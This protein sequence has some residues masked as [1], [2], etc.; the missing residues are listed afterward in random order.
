MDN[1]IYMTKKSRFPVF[2]AIALVSIL[3]LSFAVT[4]CRAKL[5]GAE[6]YY[7]S[8][9]DS[10][11]NL[12][13]GPGARYPV[14]WILTRETMPVKIIREFDVWRQIELFD[15][16]TGWVHMN[17]LSGRKTAIV[18][19]ETREMRVKPAEDARIILR[20]E[21]GVIVKLDQCVKAWCSIGVSG[22]EGWIPAA[23]LWGDT[24]AEEKSK[25]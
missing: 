2:A 14:K 10:K 16:E 6:I 7:A 17:L 12:R 25:E 9:R 3:M 8:L 21:P 13:S 20:V 15:G 11:T 22:Y 18:R 19:D 24:A 1:S 23:A 5:T 4:P